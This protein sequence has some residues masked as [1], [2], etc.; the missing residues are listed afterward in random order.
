MT[1]TVMNNYIDNIAALLNI[2]DLSRIK[3]VGVHSGST[4][5]D[6]VIEADNF[7]NST[8]NA[9]PDIS[10]ISD[11]LT[12]S[13]ADGTFA[14]VMQAN[15]GSTVLAVTSNFHLAPDTTQ[16]QTSEE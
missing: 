7:T 12:T 8:P 14:S 4:V 11:T 3:I 13:I 5:V 9:S 1:D 15:V 6:T 10:N 2:T 16:S